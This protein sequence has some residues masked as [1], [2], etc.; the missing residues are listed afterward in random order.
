MHKAAILGICISILTPSSLLA[1]RQPAETESVALRNVELSSRAELNG[2]MVSPEGHP[3]G[4]AALVVT[5]NKVTHRVVTDENGRFVVKNLRGGQCVIHTADHEVFA[6]RLWM[7][8]TAPPNSI[9]SVAIVKQGDTIVRG[10]LGLPNV[11]TS[12]TTTQ[13][14]VLGVAVFAGTTAGLVSAYDDGS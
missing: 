10:Q 5:L 9:R 4:N 1:E 12:M 11:L 8:G 14:L 13:Q 2:Q 7:H 6:C 3:I